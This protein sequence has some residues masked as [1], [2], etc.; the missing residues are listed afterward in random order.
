MATAAVVISP[1]KI[2]LKHRLLC[3][4]V[5]P[6]SPLSSPS[7]RSKRVSPADSE[8]KRVQEAFNR[9]QPV[10]SKRAL[11]FDSFEIAL[12]L[13]NRFIEQKRYSDVIQLFQKT[14][15]S[16]TTS[17]NDIA[18]FSIYF[19]VALEK[20]GQRHDAI[21]NYQFQLVQLKNI[22][23]HMQQSLEKGK[24]RCIQILNSQKTI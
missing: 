19:A 5:L 8:D 17:Q 12:S 15:P 3:D 14:H 6:V 13:S 18:Q 4:E 20:Q 24:Q 7:K 11:S 9:N 21:A 10:Q 23:P 1:S 2:T 16:P 22:S